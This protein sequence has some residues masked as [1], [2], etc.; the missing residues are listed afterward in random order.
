[1]RYSEEL[2]SCQESQIWDQCEV[3]WEQGPI[4]A[5][6][7]ITFQRNLIS[8]LSRAWAEHQFWAISWHWLRLACSGWPAGFESTCVWSSKMHQTSQSMR[9]PNTTKWRD[10]LSHEEIYFL[11]RFLG[12]LFLIY[13]VKAFKKFFRFSVR[14]IQNFDFHNFFCHI[15][16]NCDWPVV[17]G[18]QNLVAFSHSQGGTQ[19]WAVVRDS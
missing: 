6:V 7:S 3:T 1:M 8:T 13:E 17:G 4:R 19:I 16:W 11:D 2:D 10:I 15:A 18:G 14:L 9:F 12:I 5:L